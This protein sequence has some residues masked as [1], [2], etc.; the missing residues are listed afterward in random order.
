ML[1]LIYSICVFLS[2]GFIV[3]VIVEKYWGKSWRNVII[4]SLAMSCIT[5]I[6]KYYKIN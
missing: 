3:S 5:E 6:L 4:I 2:I 1:E